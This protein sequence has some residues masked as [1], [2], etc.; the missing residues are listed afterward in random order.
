VDFAFLLA[1]CVA[2]PVLAQT[3]PEAAPAPVPSAPEEGETTSLPQLQREEELESPQAVAEREDSAYAYANLAP[4]EEESLLQQY[5]APQL[6][7]IDADPARALS[8]VGIKKI[9][10]PT[11]AL[12]TVDGET[13]LLESE[14]PLRAPE[15]DGDLRKVELDLEETEGGYEPAN[16]L[17]DLSL[18]DSA[19]EPIAIGDL[20]LTITP[21]GTGAA[22][23]QPLSGEDLFLPA[24]R[25]DTSLLLS[26]I[27]GGLELSA[28]LVSRDS[29]EQ[30]GFDVGL[31]QGATLH[32]TEAG[33]AEVRNPV[34]DVLATITAPRAFDAQGTEVPVTLAVAGST[35]SLSVPHRELDVAY[36]LFVDPQII[37]E[38]WWEFSDT[39]K[40]S[41]W[42]WSWSGV[43]GAEDYIGRTS[44]IVSPCWGRGL[45][46]RARSNFT[47]PAGS[48]GRWWFTPQGSTTYIRR[49]ILGPINYDTRGCWANEPHGYVGVWNDWSG[50]KVRSNAYPT[51]WGSYVDTGSGQN[52]GGGT[53]TVFVGIHAGATSNL[54]CG[55]DYQLGGATLFLDDPEHPT[56]GATSGYPSGWAKKG[57]TFTINAP[58]SDPGLGVKK[59][60]LSLGG[61]V[62][63]HRELGCDGHY[64]NPCPANHT[65]Q[66]PID[67]ASFDEG[68]KQLRFSAVDAIEKPSNTYE[69]RL[70]VDRTP[71][72]IDLGGELAV[73]TEETV[74]DDKD[75][76]D[77]DD[78]PLVLPVYKLAIDATDG[79]DPRKEAIGE[80]DKR[81]GVKKIEVF[82]D[83][84]TTPQQ[85]WEA[86]T[87]SGGN[88]PMSQVFT[89]KLNE[90]SP[91][92]DHVLKVV[93]RDFAGNEP[94]ERKLEFEYIP[95]TGM[96]DEYVMQYFPLPDGSGNEAEEEH[97]SRPELAV[98]L[99]NGNLVYRELDVDVEGPAA[100]LELERYYNSLQPPSQDTEWGDGWT[101]AQTPTLELD[102]P[103]APGAP[104]E[105]EMLEAGGGVENRIELPVNPGEEQFDKQLQ[106]VVTKEAGGYVVEDESGETGDIVAFDSSGQVSEERTGGAAA[107]DYSYEGGAIAEIEVEDPATAAVDPEELTPAAEGP[108]L[109]ISHVAD[110]GSPGAAAGQLD[111]PSDVAAD[112][113]G[114]LWVLDAANNRVQKFA[115]S[116]EFLAQFGGPGTGDG[117]FNNPSA[118]AID[119]AGNLWIADQGNHR[120]QKF[121][122]SGQFVSK[123]G[124]TGFATGKLLGPTGVA[125]GPDGS[126]WVS[127]SLKVQR[128]TTAG[129]FID[130]VGSNGTA[131]GQVNSPQA[132]ALGPGGNVYVADAGNKRIAV[133]NAEG[134]FQRQ[135]STVTGTGQLIEPT[136]VDLDEAGNVWVADSQAD[137]V[138]LF[139]SAGA[140]VMAFGSSGSG[141]GQFG[142]DSSAGVSSDGQGRLWVAD[143]ENDRVQRWLVAQFT[144]ALPGF[145]FGAPGAAPGQ[146]DAPADV[147]IDAQDNLWVL[148]SANNRV[149]KFG[150]SGELLTQF[151]GLGSG[152]GQL[153][154]PSS[155]AIDS[156]GDLWIADQGNHRVQRFSPTGQFLSKFGETGFAVG[157][158][159]A[160]TGIAVGVDGSIWVSDS[161]KVQR[162][163]TAGTFIER[164]GTHGAGPGQISS[165]QAL[166]VG[167][168]GHV[169]VAD[170]GN[171]RIDVFDKEGDYVRHWGAA[172]AGQGQFSYPSEVEVDGGGN[173][174]V[175]DSPDNQVELFDSAGDHLA[176]LGSAGSGE[177][178]FG[179]NPAAGISSDGKGRVWIGDPEN[180]RVQMWLAGIYEPTA[181]EAPKEDDAAVEIE[182][183]EGLVETVEGDEVG[184]L[185]YEHSGD[186]LT[187]VSTPEGETTYAYD[188][189]GRMTK[190]TLANGNYAEIAY[191][192]TYG[193]VKSVTV[194][195]GSAAPKTTHFTYS[196]DP[197]RTMV[198]PPDAPATTYDIAADGSI[199]KWWNAKQ[200]PV[201]DDIAGS[202]YD[203]YNRETSHPIPVGVHTL[204]VQAHDDEGIASIQVIANGNQLVDEKT[205]QHDPAE[206]GKC[207]TQSSEWVTETGNWP[208]GILQLEV[209]AMDRLGEATSQRFWV[210][211]PYTPPLDPEAEEAPRFNEILRFREEFGL[212]LDLKGDE[213]AIN[214]RIFDLM[215]DWHNPSTPEG[216]VARASW[217]RWGVPLRQVDVAE[218]DY[219]EGYIDQ[220]VPL[221]EDWA[222]AHRPHTFAGYYVDHRSGG[223]MHIGFTSDQAGALAEIKQQV[224]VN[225]PIRLAVF[226]V[227]PSVTRASLNDTLANVEALWDGDP[228]LAETIV[229]TGV[230]EASNAVEVTG[231]NTSLIE[232]RLKDV[233][234]Q[235]VP[236]K[237]TYEDMG[238]EFGG[239]NHID[240]RILAGDRILGHKGGDTYVPCTAGFG[241][242][243]RIGT[244]SN[245][246]P[247]YAPFVLTAGHCAPIGRTFHRQNSGGAVDPDSLKKIGHS[248]RTGLPRGGQEYETD[249][250]AIRLSSAG[251]MPYYIF[252]NKKK[253]KPVGP[254]FA[255]KTGETLCFSGVATNARK[256]GEFV[257]VRRRNAG[258]PG[259]QLF[260][261]TRFAGIPGDSGSPVWSP[262]TGRAVG[263]LSGGPGVAGLVK[264]WVTP[265]IVPR[266]QNPNKI[267]GILNAPGMKSLHLALPGD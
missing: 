98:N 4:A 173:V 163:T 38:N 96:K 138:Q 154:N 156:A 133:F 93:A 81:S 186:L 102:D 143:P 254:A 92:K 160:P 103:A 244:K 55:R 33:G 144:S 101:L 52:L 134:D 71:P 10:S 227:A 113:Q 31:P 213:S 155:L 221:I 112:A 177:G 42:H 32:A 259:K 206:P 208:P 20:G 27:A 5:F 236:L 141:K 118:L 39:S 116:G 7:A 135:F 89:L 139:D 258:N 132:L 124:E 234:G 119:A 255:P 125:I 145:N 50:W 142:L 212:D 246:E 149:Q 120:V 197:H 232:K 242:W 35:I 196:D 182:A 245:G 215:G 247:Q 188:G 21:Q 241:A 194:K 129:A 166:A 51:G 88:C 49:A 28:L 13:V 183:S 180:D 62:L 12:V 161:L 195:I 137:R 178:Q 9:H 126:V 104:T 26:P 140:P 79:K 100:D 181:E 209:I 235:Q 54:N 153:N 60:S 91:D 25:E 220:N 205:C 22:G 231:T 29:P 175:A 16:P 18:P 86:S 216:E 190:V 266:R 237:V 66:F 223:I 68:E 122:A 56:A 30:L 192:A 251:L 99:V 57:S 46:V 162:F 115:P 179:L 110:V 3:S 94:R 152:D 219:R 85:T 76:D 218:M 157:K 193:R 238:I 48:W 6:N 201:L 15:E 210:N 199:F 257:G 127:D 109:R 74:S 73:A 63:L 211:I 44:C 168:G 224:P 249:G 53:R 239:R 262:Q 261:I 264:D 167:P 123:F 248:A 233:L 41:Y 228:E 64:S 61:S 243:D 169:Y 59:A 171:K 229:S 24:A 151:G 184:T 117:Q 185:S 187:A 40:L 158:L 222:E 65:F 131:P 1:A 252:L 159:T 107:V 204:V 84:S 202:L 225:A 191:E 75:A 77:K 37:E 43:G 240:G 260:I 203:V 170:A 58:A 150:P 121:N 23:A 83:D 106:A 69:W 111:A 70:K 78:K 17:V 67:A 108:P 19:D 14:V 217:E 263:L 172:G 198:T 164:V 165:P 230:D 34:G 147:V 148:D 200:P 8:E 265:L 189:A 256:C 207:V 2:A 95:A 267:P 174:W 226:P 114:N 82:I 214:D 36:P 136:E 45:Y 72:E 176:T 87:C 97:P 250:A 128:F 253:P 11:E 146:L 105:G 80:G 47:Y 90:L 130:R